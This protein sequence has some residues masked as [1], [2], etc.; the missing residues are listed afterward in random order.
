MDASLADAGDAPV[1]PI[2]RFVDI[3]ASDPI[4]RRAGRVNPDPPLRLVPPDT[5]R[6][7]RRPMLRFLRNAF[8]LR[9]AFR[10]LRRRRR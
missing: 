6:T 10:F 1:R 9:E 8:I 7:R 4:R 2:A 5:A 3:C